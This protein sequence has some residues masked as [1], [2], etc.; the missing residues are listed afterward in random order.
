MR[1][2][3]IKQLMISAEIIFLVYILAH[4]YQNGTKKK[5]NCSMILTSTPNVDKTKTFHPWRAEI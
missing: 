4:N 3:K 2:G 1:T 5:K